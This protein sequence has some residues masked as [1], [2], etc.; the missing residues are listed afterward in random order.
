MSSTPPQNPSPRVT[1]LDVA[2]AA[3]VSRSTVSRI[4]NGTA[5]VTPDKR[6]AVEAAIRQLNYRPDHAARSLKMGRSMT[7]GVLVQDIESPFFTRLL[8]GIEEGLAGSGYVAIIVTGHWNPVA[9]E[10]R[11][12]LLMAR[13]VDGLVVLAGHLPDSRLLALAEHQPIVV[14]GR[15][16]AGPAVDGVWFDQFEVGR[17]ATRHLLD[18]GHRRIA[19]IAGPPDQADAVA[20]HAGY[21]K[22]LEESG[23]APEPAL[24]VR[25]DFTEIGGLLAMNRLLDG[26]VTFSAVF[27]ANDQTAYGVRMALYRRGL[28]VPDDLSVIGVD[29]LPAAALLTPAQ[30]TVR[31]PLYELGRYAASSLLRMLGHDVA[32]VQVPPLELV[33]RETTRRI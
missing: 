20:R 11:I 25:G 14:T 15:T 4:L 18:C 7:V 2:Q 26:G 6:A 19:H 24:I 5:R 31:Q 1:E 16:L 28:R 23:L 22:A 33:I 9:E 8:R 21:V 12:Q 13:R 30:T 3:G 29:D 17:M 10:E 32:L 27:A